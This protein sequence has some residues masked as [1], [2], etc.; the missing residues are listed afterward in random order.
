MRTDAAKNLKK[1]AIEVMKDPLA[2]EQ[3]IAN[4]AGVSQSTVSNKLVELGKIERT[5]A[6]VAIEDADLEIVSLTQSINL[7]R[8]RD[9]TERAKIKAIELAHIG[10]ISQERYSKFAGENT[11]NEGGEKEHNFI[12]VE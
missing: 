9:E 6:K 10:K 11:N 7:E 12:M 5:K 1:V 3:E 4:R 8:L 2:S